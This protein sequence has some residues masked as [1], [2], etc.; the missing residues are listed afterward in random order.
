MSFQDITIVRQYPIINNY[1]QSDRYGNAPLSTILSISGVGTRELTVHNQKWVETVIGGTIECCYNPPSTLVSRVVTETVIEETP[2]TPDWPP[3]RSPEPTQT[4]CECT[5]DDNTFQATYLQATFYNSEGGAP[6]IPPEQCNCDNSFASP[7]VTL[8]P[9]TDAVL[10]GYPR[11]TWIAYPQNGDFRILLSY[12]SDCLW[13]ITIQCIRGRQE[14]QTIW[15]GSNPTSTQYGLYSTY[16]QNDI[17]WCADI[18][19]AYVA[20]GTQPN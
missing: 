5:I 10:E 14:Y 1:V 13:I 18:A 8:I 20:V 3:T 15:Q 17:P 12:T 4:P 9:Y 11:C 7:V 6:Y 16:I 19:T 2:R